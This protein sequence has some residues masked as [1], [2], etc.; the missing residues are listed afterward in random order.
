[1]P[2]A[3]LPSGWPGLRYFRLHGAPRIYYSA[4][5][6]A[7]LRSLKLR[8]GAASSSGETWCIFDNT[9]AGAAL[10]NALDLLT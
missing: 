4:Y 8:L 2:G 3:D 10:E 6:G 1:M 5:D 7:F 9:A